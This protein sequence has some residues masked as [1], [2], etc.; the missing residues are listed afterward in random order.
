M[1]VIYR[2]VDYVPVSA[3]F[4]SILELFR[5][6]NCSDIHFMASCIEQALETCCVL[7]F[8]Y[9]M[10]YRLKSENFVGKKRK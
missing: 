2:Y 4:D 5:H 7:H 6:W 8:Y 3:I 10:P 9:Y 1:S